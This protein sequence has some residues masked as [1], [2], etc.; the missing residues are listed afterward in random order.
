[1]K[2]FL[3][4]LVALGTC[5][6][7]SAQ[8]NN[9]HVVNLTGKVSL[10]G[11]ELHF[12]DSI[13]ISQ[14]KHVI[15]LNDA[16][17]ITLC[18]PDSGVVRYNLEAFEKFTAAESERG[19]S[20]AL[21][22]LLGFKYNYQE[23]KSRGDCKCIN[24]LDCLLPNSEISEWTIL[25]Q[26]IEFSSH[27]IGKGVFFVQFENEGE[28]FNKFLEQKAENVSIDKDVFL[29]NDSTYF[30]FETP[31]F[32]GFISDKNASS[33]PEVICSV[34]FNILNEE[35]I[36]KHLLLNKQV[37]QGL[38]QDRIQEE[39]MYSLYASFGK[40]NWCYVEKWLE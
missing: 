8:T 30:N 37:L 16:S 24:P 17:A 4:I 9:W 3:L 14:I 15:L 1:M 11:Y 26:P 39:I 5:I 20:D 25:S 23:L 7:L 38:P 34:K 29:L 10:N 33:S 21:A 40:P 13:S 6:I 32:I 2:N 35:Q 31:A 22:D 12:G 27:T 19:F 36:E 28:T 18:H